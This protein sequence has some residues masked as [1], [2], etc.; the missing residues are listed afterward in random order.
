MGSPPGPKSRSRNCMSKIKQL[1]DT[2]I[3]KQEAG[4]WLARLDKGDLSD[5]EHM[6]LQRWMSTSEFHASYLKRLVINWDRMDVLGELADLFPLKSTEHDSTIA[7]RNR[8]AW[9]G[10]AVAAVALLVVGLSNSVTPVDVQKIELPAPVVYHTA[11]GDFTSV[12]LTDG[13]VMKL[14]TNSLVEVEFDAELRSVTL[15][16]GEASFKVA[17]DPSKPFVVRGG[18][19]AAW[20]VGTQF[21]VRL[22]NDA[23]DVTVIEGRVKV[24]TGAGNSAPQGMIALLEDD[25]SHQVLLQ[26]GESV[27]YNQDIELLKVHK[28]SD[29]DQKLAWQRGSLIF[30][31]E[32]LQDAVSEIS[33]YTSLQLLIIDPEINDI[34][35]GGHFKTDDIEGLLAALATNFDI[36]VDQVSPDQ[37]HLYHE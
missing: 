29:I 6:D 36:R 24:M 2:E 9:A 34:P 15:L 18:S 22:L 10:A 35:I 14:N 23:V 20:A 1:P 5:Q 4:A 12:K 27:R 11:I 8:L 32:S 21:N 3:I 7:V 13:T 25:R 31:G 26:A 30:N 19:G 17:S 28:Q 37:V 16:R 33:R